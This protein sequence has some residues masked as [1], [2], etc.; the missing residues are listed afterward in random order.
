[1]GGDE[2]AGGGGAVGGFDETGR[3]PGNAGKIGYVTYL[4]VVFSSVQLYTVT[5]ILV[6][7][8]SLR[9]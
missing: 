5:S 9:C 3:R 1:M 8:T 2:N 4:S 7:H 6:G